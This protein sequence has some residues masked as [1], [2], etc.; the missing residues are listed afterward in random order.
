MANRSKVTVGYNKE[1]GMVS[2]NVSE[3]NEHLTGIQTVT[4]NLDY[5]GCKSLAS[6]LEDAMEEIP[7]SN[8]PVP[9]TVEGIRDFS[10]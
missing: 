4:A 10:K 7:Q 1:I 5:E 6:V 2:L 3:M 8:R 9:A